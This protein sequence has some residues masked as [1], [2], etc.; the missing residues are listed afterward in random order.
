MLSLKLRYCMFYSKIV[1]IYIGQF[2]TATNYHKS[3]ILHLEH[4]GYIHHQINKDAEH[5]ILN[6]DF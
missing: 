4:K 2:V 6:Y 3:K 5:F 1:N